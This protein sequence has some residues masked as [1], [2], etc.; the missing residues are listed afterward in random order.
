MCLEL[1]TAVTE[2]EKKIKDAGGVVQLVA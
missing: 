2:A 1:L